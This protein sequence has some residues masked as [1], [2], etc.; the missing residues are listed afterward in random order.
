MDK[1]LVKEF[2]EVMLANGFEVIKSN[3]EQIA[4]NNKEGTSPLVV[5]NDLNYLTPT[6]YQWHLIEN[7]IKR[8]EGTYER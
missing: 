5:N 4:I 2:L 3:S 1:A 6:P 8:L 7:E